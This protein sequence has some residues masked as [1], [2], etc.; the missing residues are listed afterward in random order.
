M[1]IYVDILIFIDIFPASASVYR[2]SRTYGIA[3][4]RL[5]LD[6][7]SLASGVTLIAASGRRHFNVTSNG[8][9]RV[10]KVTFSGGRV[11]RTTNAYGGSLLIASGG[12][13]VLSS[14]TF[15]N[16]TVVVPS[17]TAVAGGGAV[18]V[19][20]R[21]KLRMSDCRLSG[22]SAISLT[23]AQGG[24]LHVVNGGAL[25]LWRTTFVQNVVQVSYIHDTVFM[26]LVDIERKGP[27]R[28]LCT[29]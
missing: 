10:N 1:L 7:S 25:S 2:L 23:N 13:G 26:G 11:R 20:G 5:T 3:G 15:I 29:S 24:A 16:N 19:T 8:W 6:A 27:K 28:V 9:L 4:R 17:G 14:C 12:S 18:Y 22:N 21:G